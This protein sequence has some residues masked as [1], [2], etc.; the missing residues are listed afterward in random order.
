[1]TDDIVDVE[2]VLILLLGRGVF[3]RGYV[4]AVSP[5]KYQVWGSKLLVG[6]QRMLMVNIIPLLLCAFHAH[7]KTLA[8]LAVVLVVHVALCFAQITH[9]FHLV[10]ILRFFLN[11]LYLIIVRPYGVV[12]RDDI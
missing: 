2:I 6:S 1:M 5:F 10:Q 8:T 9:D 7:K 11:R 12:Y 3:V 4:S